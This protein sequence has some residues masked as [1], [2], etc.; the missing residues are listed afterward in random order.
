MQ[1]VLGMPRPITAL[2]PA[3]AVWDWH[4]ERLGA[5]VGEAWL[6]EVKTYESEVL[7]GR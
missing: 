2:L 7:S 4:C 3:G 1:G 5:P 6:A